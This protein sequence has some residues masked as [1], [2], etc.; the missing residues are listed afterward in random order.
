MGK[1]NFVL[2]RTNLRSPPTKKQDFINKPI[3]QYHLYI[4]AMISPYHLYHLFSYFFSVLSGFSVTSMLRVFSGG[5][6]IIAIFLLFSYKNP[7]YTINLM[8]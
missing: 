7:P 4:I 5:F 1:L 8:T 2:K 3:W 6:F